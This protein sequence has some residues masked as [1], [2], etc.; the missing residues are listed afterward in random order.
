MLEVAKRFPQIASGRPELSGDGFCLGATFS[1]I[2]DA[3]QR[4]SRTLRG[5]VGMTEHMVMRFVQA[6]TMRMNFHRA[7]LEHDIMHGQPSSASI[8]GQVVVNG[9]FTDVCPSVQ[10]EHARVTAAYDRSSAW[11]NQTAA[12]VH[13]E[14][15][16]LLIIRRTYSRIQPTDVEDSARRLRDPMHDYGVLAAIAG[17][18]NQSFW[19]DYL[20]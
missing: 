19:D 10:A 9:E 1:R 17:A 18:T 4:H 12:A 20:G 13:A 5:M 6:G 15:A 14:V 7:R 11:L 3:M 8:Q 16:E 2:E